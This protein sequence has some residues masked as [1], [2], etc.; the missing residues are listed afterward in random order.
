QARGEAL[1]TTTDVYS[2]GVILY[3]LLANQRPYCVVGKSSTEAV[4]MIC[5]IEPVKP[6]ALVRNRMKR[7]PGMPREAGLSF[8]LDAVVAKAMRK[9]PQQRYG[10][11][12]DVADDI[13]KYLGGLPVLAH[14]GS[15]RYSVT[16][17]IGRHKLAAASVVAVLTLMVT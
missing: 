15:L 6:S 9:D 10:S 17:F 12:Q 5:E 16:K 13:S 14:R 7:D 2:L 8:E 11:A 3:E 4:R 1:T